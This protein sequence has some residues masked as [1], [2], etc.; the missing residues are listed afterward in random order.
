VT[1]RRPIHANFALRLASFSG[2][3]NARRSTTAVLNAKR[4]TGM[5]T[6]KIASEVLFGLCY[7]L[8]LIFNQTEK[9][10]DV[11]TKRDLF[12]TFSFVRVLLA[13]RL[14]LR[15]FPSFLFLVLLCNYDLVTTSNCNFN[16]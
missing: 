14:R 8:S 16:G 10:I 7:K 5:S 2:A 11:Y 9:K 13:E 15:F 1:L 6:R 4:K 3:A 12:P